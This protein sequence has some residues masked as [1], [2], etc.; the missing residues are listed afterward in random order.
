MWLLLLLVTRD[1]IKL[2]YGGLPVSRCTPKTSH[3][4]CAQY[5]GALIEEVDRITGLTT[6]HAVPASA[7]IMGYSKT[8]SILGTEGWV[9]NT[10]HQLYYNPSISE[11]ELTFGVFGEFSFYAFTSGTDGCGGMQFI[12]YDFNPTS[13]AI[14]SLVCRDTLDTVVQY[15]D[16]TSLQVVKYSECTSSLN[17][18]YTACA[19]PVY[20]ACSSS[21][22]SP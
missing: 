5:E 20:V 11:W 12:N 19:N 15:R 14:I 7:P 3:C 21:S 17:P 18:V 9:G 1:V 13:Y 4:F 22:L 2:W 8:A 16:C 6:L 10:L